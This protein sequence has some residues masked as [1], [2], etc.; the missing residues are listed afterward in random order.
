MSLYLR[1]ISI[2]LRKED[3]QRGCI[4]MICWEEY[5]DWGERSDVG[6]EEGGGVNY[7][8]EASWR[9]SS[10]NY[11][12]DEEKGSAVVVGLCIWKS[13]GRRPLRLTNKNHLMTKINLRYISLCCIV[14]HF[15]TFCISVCY[16]NN[17]VHTSQGTKC[18]SIRKTSRLLLQR[19]VMVFNCNN[20][21][22]HNN[23]VRVNKMYMFHCCTRPC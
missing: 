22:I 21:T 8:M 13:E 6:T 12:D 17:S 9:H 1:L 11:K 5:I 3:R 23:K 15:I 4:K 18:A 7:M 16:V 20:R 14:V 2:L 10:P 19:E